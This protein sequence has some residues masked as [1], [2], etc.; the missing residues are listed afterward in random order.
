M[1]DYWVDPYQHEESECAFCGS[2]YDLVN[3]HVRNASR[4]GKTTI[5]ACRRCNSSMYSYTLAEWLRMLKY[6]DYEFHQ[7][8]WQV[9]LDYHWHRKT[10][11]ANRGHGSLIRRPE[12]C[13][14]ECTSVGS[15]KRGIHRR[16]LVSATGTGRQV[17]RHREQSTL[18][19]RARPSFAARRPAIRTDH[20]AKQRPGGPG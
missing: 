14:T 20:R 2:Q 6:S 13:P 17:P 19:C 18:C 7:K 8:K 15:D 16:S 5:V 1:P 10:G 3:A 12:G 4:G 11:L 9:I